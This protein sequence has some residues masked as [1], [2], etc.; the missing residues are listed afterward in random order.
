MKEKFFDKEYLNSPAFISITITY[1]IT[2]FVGYFTALY[3]AWFMIF[4]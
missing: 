2:V 3:T 1:V 4:G